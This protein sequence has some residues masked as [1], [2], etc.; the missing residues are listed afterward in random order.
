MPGFVDTTV[1]DIDGR[2]SELRDERRASRR[3]GRR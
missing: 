3:H 1:K 2:L